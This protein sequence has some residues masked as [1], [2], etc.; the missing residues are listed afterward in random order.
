MRSLQAL[1]QASGAADPGFGEFD[2]AQYEIRAAAAVRVQR[3]AEMIV[4]KHGKGNRVR[5]YHTG[6]LVGVLVPRKDFEKK[7]HS[8]SNIPGIVVEELKN[9][10]IRVRYCTSSKCWRQE[11]DCW[12]GFLGPSAVCWMLCSHLRT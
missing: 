11:P 12:L 3:N 2:A 4:R 10:M 1:A 6:Q 5:T 8:S 9:N 7:L